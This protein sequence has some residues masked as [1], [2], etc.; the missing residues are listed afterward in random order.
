MRKQ[1]ARSSRNQQAGSATKIGE[2]SQQ[3]IQE[4]ISKHFARPQGDLPD[5]ALEEPD[6]SGLSS[7][8]ESTEGPVNRPKC[9]GRVRNCNDTI[10]CCPSEKKQEKAKGNFLDEMARRG[11][12]RE[13]Q[14]LAT[15]HRY[16][17]C[18]IGC[19]P[20]S[21]Q[22]NYQCL[23]SS[24]S[25]STAGTSEEGQSLRTKLQSQVLLF[26]YQRRDR[27][28]SPSPKQGLPSPKVYAAL[29]PKPNQST[30]ATPVIAR[31][32]I[33]GSQLPTSSFGSRPAVYAESLRVLK[34]LSQNRQDACKD[35]DKGSNDI[36]GKEYIVDD[37]EGETEPQPVV[38][39]IEEEL[40]GENE[41]QNPSPVPVVQSRNA[42]RGHRRAG[43][44]YIDGKALCEAL[45]KKNV[46][47]EQ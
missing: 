25:N 15:L 6:S 44:G 21:I 28:S 24:S 5:E 39:R 13:I 27:S 26:P 2:L 9:S 45:E 31:S 40:A 16:I 22:R 38:P 35:S 14:D 37:L 32:F 29:S 1:T 19:S 11:L 34:V 18:Q 4:L 43:S 47:A 42:K 10:C 8:E 30:K 46:V 20:R 23:E 33:L 36:S 12:Q 3:M 7:F 17:N 41:A